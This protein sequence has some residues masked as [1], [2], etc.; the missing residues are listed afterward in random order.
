MNLSDVQSQYYFDVLGEIQKAHQE[1]PKDRLIRLRQV[2]ESFLKDLTR[3]E[4]QVFSDTFARSIYVFNE[5]HVPSDLQSGAN[6]FRRAANKCVH[7]MGFV[8][9]ESQVTSGVTVLSQ[10]VS[11][12]AGIPTPPALQKAIAPPAATVPVQPAKPLGDIAYVRCVVIDPGSSNNPKRGV[13][14]GVE[15]PEGLDRITIVLGTE[16]Q[17]TPLWPYA[18]VSITALHPTGSDTYSTT[19]DSLLVVEP[20]V[21]IDATAISNCFLMNGNN[22]LISLLSRFQ[23]SNPSEAQVKGIIVGSI[24]GYLL[25]DPDA[26]FDDCFRR[27]A[28]NSAVFMTVLGANHDRLIRDEVQRQYQVLRHF[29]QDLKARRI[30]VEASFLSNEFGIQGRLDALI[31]GNKP[32]EDQ[33]IELKSGRPSNGPVTINIEGIPVSVRVWP[34]QLAQAACYNLLMQSANADFQGTESIFYSADPISPIRPIQTSPGMRRTII[35]LRNQITAHE[36]SLAKGDTTPIRLLT[37]SNL[38]NAPSYLTS[39]VVALESALAA[40]NPAE[41]AYFEAFC[42]LVAR[43]HMTA[44]IGSSNPDS[45]ENGFA[46]L[47][48]NDLQSKDAEYNAIPF[49]VLD[50]VDRDSSM[51][52][53][54][55]ERTNGMGASNFREGDSVVLYHHNKDWTAEPLRQ[56]LV[57][58]SLR[59]L[60]PTKGEVIV[61]VRSGMAQLDTPGY[62]TIESDMF[63]SSFSTQYRSLSRFI[64]AQPAKR[65]MIL[66]KT[67]PRTAA[68]LQQIPAAIIDSHHLDDHQRKVLKAALESQDYF[69]LQGP[70]GTGKTQVMLSA[71]LE[72]LYKQT[73]QKILLLAYTN[74]AVTEICKAIEDLKGIDFIRLGSK[75]GL[76]DPLKCLD[77]YSKQKT[78]PETRQLI[79]QT[80]VFVSTV[81][82][83]LSRPELLAYKQFD[84]TIVDEASQLLE[85]HLAGLLSEVSRFILIGDEKQLPAVITQPVEQT[86]VTDP[87]LISLGIKDLR[88][89]L[90]E[91]LVTTCKANNWSHAFAMLETQGRMHEKIQ[92]FPSAR[93]YDGRLKPLK[94]WQTSA[95]QKFNPSSAN[96]IE[97]M[98]ASS[99]VLFIPSGQEHETRRHVEEAKRIVALLETIY[100]V[101]GKDFDPKTTV[102]VIT[103]FRAQIS[104]IRRRLPAYLQEQDIPIDTVERFQGSQREIILMSL[105]VNHPLQMATIQSLSLDNSVDRKLNVAITRARRHLVIL[106]NPNVLQ[107]QTIYADLIQHILVNGGYSPILLIE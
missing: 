2:Y 94:S 11:F 106:G 7:E 34:S 48:L 102:G 68:L 45:N 15:Y 75:E 62:W 95:E 24:F 57:R 105:A 73:N 31:E 33:I 107:T 52:T 20:D 35:N 53:F 88:T 32:E 1:S 50:S 85:P 3:N 6:S 99:R 9:N 80:R 5:L 44:R 49:L 74:R 26:S 60:K 12:I 97:K 92:A 56:Q 89:S 98:L 81:S 66:G 22:P 27:A 21:L 42:T 100:K 83:A 82:S 47:W 64:K 59:S 16:W 79:D 36:W 65:N 40:A 84:I 93:F 38:T 101:Y 46:S 90:F 91:R 13:V 61:E 18:T 103:P 67:K 63:D 4:K 58:G 70:P 86:A 96:P 28:R 39:D 104:E 10:I 87:Q 71:M 8:A 55:S 54:R 78:V 77:E 25:M 30:H 72:Y 23:A 37:R 29:V 14:C 17:Q 19:K 41:R 43:E 76:A 69:L 51:A